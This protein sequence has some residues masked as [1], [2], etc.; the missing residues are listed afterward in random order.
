MRSFWTSFFYRLLRIY[1]QRHGPRLL[2]GNAR[3]VAI[4][5]RD[6]SKDALYLALGVLSAAF[7]LEAFLIPNGFIDGGVTGISLL[8]NALSG[9]PISF[10]LVLINLPF[11]ALAFW[12]VGSRFALKSMGSIV[13]LAL[14]VEL[15]PFPV[16][17]EDRI[18]I[19]TFG[20][21]F[22]GLGIGMAVRGGGIL[23]GTE[24]LAIFL[25]R[26]LS[27]SVG[28]IILIF[29]VMIFSVAAYVLSIEI[30]LYA[31]LTYFAASRTIDFVVDGIEEYTGVTVISRKSEAVRQAI[32]NNLG[33]GCTIYQGKSGYAPDGR[34]LQELD[35]VFTV[36]TRLEIARCKTEI[37]KVDEQAFVIMHSIKDTKGGMVKKRPLSKLL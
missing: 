13:L 27:M 26:R 33:R 16:L 1:T 22:L 12:V 15:V 19:A 4:E 29:N 36:I 23:D 30:A 35:I 2:R 6:E 24:V 25:S 34:S 21:F 32:V 10:L 20:G 8:V 18:L 5:L 3:Q 31:I 17:T 28:N 14:T 9:W 11:I 7:G 37:N